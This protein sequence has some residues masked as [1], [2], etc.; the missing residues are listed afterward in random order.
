M[1][2]LRS[3]W[4]AIRLHAHGRGKRRR[5]GYFDAVSVDGLAILSARSFPNPDL[6]ALRF[7]VTDPAT[8]AS[9]FREVDF[10]HYIDG[11]EL[12]VQDDAYVF[13]RR[14]YGISKYVIVG[15]YSYLLPNEAWTEMHEIS[16]AGAQLFRQN[17]FN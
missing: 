15:D 14:P 10:D 17:T 2:F 7:N 13:I 6:G 1:G 4:N 11:R 16:L 8:I 9:L 3:I 5:G 12:D